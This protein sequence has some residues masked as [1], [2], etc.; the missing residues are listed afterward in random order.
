MSTKGAT[1]NW[2]RW[3]L[4]ALLLMVLL[5]L[6]AVWLH[7]R[8]GF[9]SLGDPEPQVLWE[10]PAFDLVAQNGS[11]VTR[12]DLAG[13][14]WVAN[15]IFTRCGV[16][17]PL[18]TSRMAALGRYLPPGARRV[19]ITVDPGHDTPEVLARYARSYGAADDWLFLTG[20]EEEIASLAR[21]GFR[22][23]VAPAAEDAP[24]RHLEPIT[25]ST[26]FVLVDAEGRIRGFYDAFEQDSLRQLERDLARLA[27]PRA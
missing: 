5:G 12:G 16:T 1:G 7:A 17:C 25:H 15:L 13:H 18:M 11:A 22:L 8:R 23:G 6:V 3:A 2:L 9:E 24:D 27:R 21:E 26:R 4:W 19:S 10:L 14:P 20:G